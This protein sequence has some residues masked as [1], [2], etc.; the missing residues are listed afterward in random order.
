MELKR[1]QR[2]VLERIF[3]AHEHNK[4]KPSFADGLEFRLRSIE[5]Q[6]T[7]DQDTIQNLRERVENSLDL[8]RR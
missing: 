8:V 3:I 4:E 5:H 6:E 2:A 1:Y 7:I